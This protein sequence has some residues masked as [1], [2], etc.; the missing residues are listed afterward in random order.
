[1]NGLAKM[2]AQR[3][4]PKE[5]PPKSNAPKILNKTKV[6]WAQKRLIAPPN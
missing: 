6:F 2:R 1:M 5:P 4:V 3:N